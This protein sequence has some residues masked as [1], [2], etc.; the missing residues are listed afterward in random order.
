[1]NQDLQVQLDQIQ[2]QAQDPNS[3]GN[4]L[5][6]EV[7]LPGS[8]L[9]IKT[10]VCN[11]MRSNTPVTSCPLS[12]CQLEDKRAEM[13]K[14]LISMRVQHQSLQKHHSFT[15]QQLQRMKVRTPEP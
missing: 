6:A 8:N 15:K 10:P 2:Q 1:M 4:S 3:K 13:E 14:Q 11:V 12:E 9:Q 7:R 5:F